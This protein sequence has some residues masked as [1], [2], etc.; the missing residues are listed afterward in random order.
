MARRRSASSLPALLSAYLEECLPAIRREAQGPR[1]ARL[2][3]ELVATERW[4]SFDKFHATTKTLARAY[5]EAGAAAEVYR[6]PTGGALG[7]GRWVIHEA[8]DVRALRA[9]IL[10]PAKRVLADY[11]ENPWH[12]VQWSGATTKEGLTGEVLVVDDREELKGLPVQRLRGRFVLTKL[13]PREAYKPLYQAGALGVLVDTPVKDLPDAVGWAKFGWGSVPIEDGLARLAGV[14][15][16]QRQG[17]ALRALCAREKKVTLRVRADIQR[18]RGEH[19]VVSGLVRGSGD[20]QDEVWAVAHSAEPGALDNASGVAVCVEAARVLETLIRQGKLRRPRRTIRFVSGFECYGFFHFLEHGRRLQPPLAGLCVDTLGA[21]PELCGGGLRWHASVPSSAGFVNDL[22]EAV[23]RAAMK[24]GDA[25]YAYE[26]RRFVSTEDTLLGDPEYGFPCPWLTNHPFRGY[27]SSADTPELLH[28][29]GLKLCAAVVAAYLHY[30]ADAATP[31]ALELANWQTAKAVEALRGLGP[32]RTGAQ[33]ALLRESHRRS[34]R[35]LQRWLW[36]G[37][38]QEIH[39]H[40]AACERLVRETAARWKPKPPA[41]R[42]HALSRHVP[43]RSAPLAPSPYNTLPE[44]NAR[45]AAAG[46]P[47]W[48]HYW[49]DGVMPLERIAELAEAELGKPVAFEKLAEF[50]RAMADLGYVR[51]I[52][53]KAMAAP[54]KLLADLRRLGVKPGMDL[55]VHSA[56]S[57]VGPVQGGPDTVIDALL[58]AVG[59][60]GTILMPSFN[61]FAARVYNP[62]TTP[63]LNGALPDVFWR[64]PEAVRS[65][66]GSHAV[67]AIGPKAAWFCQGHLEQGIW[68]AESPIGRLVHHGGFILGLGVDHTSSTAY[69]IGEISL[70]CGCLDMFGSRDWLVTQDGEVKEVKGLAWRAGACPVSPSKL[71]PALDRAGKQRHGKVGQ[72]DCVLAKA[73]DVWAMRRRQLRDACP[74]CAIKPHRRREGLYATPVKA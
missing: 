25:G 40:F 54:R 30:L 5:K 18:Y 9:E 6:A 43:R 31:E 8:A 67:A 61:H 23:I 27:H 10:A 36:G 29:P 50:F 35:R 17:E 48:I 56:L 19:D 58:E 72:A 22:G 21:R 11:A 45:L 68:A 2:V 73:Y 12:A 64:R 3:K 66:Q 44:L 71:D 26:P 16:S 59:R 69:H 49:A 74:A 24:L 47:K 46:L 60:R 63:T 52:E 15:L 7:N 55:M 51:L 33:V 41:P 28:A 14:S 32:R 65:I 53:P 39:A 1:V 70:G 34:M 38:K 42:A 37:K 57:K 4:N 20:P 13:A 62:L